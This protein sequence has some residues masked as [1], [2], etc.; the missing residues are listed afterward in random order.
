MESERGDRRESGWGEKET[1]R[2]EEGGRLRLLQRY[3][4]QW[5]IMDDFSSQ[6]TDD[7]KTLSVR[8]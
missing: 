8:S 1:E 6:D 3:F 4:S 5:W 7:H 2:E